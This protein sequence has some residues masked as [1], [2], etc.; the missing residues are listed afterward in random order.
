MRSVLAM[1]SD[2]AAVALARLAGA[3]RTLAVAESLT[4]GLVGAT[5]TAVPGASR[6]YVGGVVCYATRVKLEVLHVPEAVVE[7]YGVVSAQCATAMA[8][9][10]R[11]LMDADVGLATTG[12]AGPQRQEGRPVGLVF[13]ALADERGEQV[14]ELRL[15]GD[16]QR[17]RAAATEEAL[18]LL[19][20]RVGAFG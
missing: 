11:R 15:H 4:G 2:A 19:A 16:R 10:V 18:A 3:A 20:R 12:V 14:D 1:T 8:Q 13:V 5:L 6:S 17:I 7:E 9:G